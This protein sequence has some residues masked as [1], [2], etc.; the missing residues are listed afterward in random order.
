MKEYLSL[1]RY[2]L[3]EGTERCDRTG[4]GTISIFGYQMR[5]NLKN[6]FPLLTTKKVHLHSIIHELLWFLKGDTNISYLKNNRVTIWDKWADKNGELGPVYGKQWRH[7]SNG[8]DKEIDQIA[9][10]INQLKYTPN[11]RRIIVSAWNVSDLDKMMLFPC[12]A[13]FQFYVVNGQL[14]CQLYQRSCDVF[15]GLPFNIA[16]YSLLI[17]MI[18]QQCNFEVGDF[19]WTGGDTHLY[20]N[21]LQQAK[22][23]LMREPRPLSNLSIQRKPMSIFDYKFEDFK[24][25]NYDPHPEIKAPISV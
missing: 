6:G 18:A 11:S 12:H 25:N 3:N 24:I 15:L 21:H 16:S 13:L 14:S 8:V 1:M 23:Q 7:W 9:N 19:I 17:H 22:Q 4:T 2:V 20:I 10:V 5:F